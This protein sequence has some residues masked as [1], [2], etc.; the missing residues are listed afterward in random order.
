MAEI[1][2]EHIKVKGFKSIRDSTLQLA[3]INV[4][5]GANGAGKSNLL[6]VFDFV[7]AIVDEELRKY[8]RQAGGADRLLHYG[9]KQ[10]SVLEFE[11]V[12]HRP[13]EHRNVYHLVLTPDEE[14]NLFIAREVIGFQAAGYEQPYVRE[15]S[16][17]EFDHSSLRESRLRTEA[18]TGR[19]N[20][21][22]YVLKCIQSY[23]AYHFHDTGPFSPVK[24]ICPVRDS[25]F[26]R[27]DA[28]NLA[29]FLYRIKKDT[30]AIYEQIVETVRTVAPFFKDFVLRPFLGKD[31]ENIQLAWR[32]KSSD[33][34][35]PASSLSDGTL[36]F[37]CLAALLLQPPQ[38]LPQIVIIDEPELGLHPFA[39][40]VLV[41]MIRSAANHSQII[42][43]TQSVTLLNYF[44]PDEVVVC[45]RHDDSSTFRRL[46]ENE[47]QTWLHEY[48]LGEL[49]EKNVFGGRP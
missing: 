6:E 46:S 16:S 1:E 45:E 47:L 41:E 23:R 48:S 12:F 15:L 5:V 8:T 37:V 10:T 24:K 4:L 11:F 25:E 28:A 2:L 31:G 49:W 44:A 14:D 29:A 32:D 35:F 38:G 43:A 18:E 42:L 27:P 36:R 20:I 9:K 33:Y 21:S 22:A 34:V 30:P 40:H 19:R 3:R 17:P 26:L 13:Q 39:I 7:N